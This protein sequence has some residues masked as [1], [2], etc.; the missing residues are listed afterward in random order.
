[1]NEKWDQRLLFLARFIAQWSRDPSTKTG[2]V[3]ADGKRVV[4]VGYNG[5]AA[6]VGDN[7]ERYA[8]R[9]LK[10]KI[11]VH[12]ERNAVLL[13][14]QPIRGCTLYTWPFASCAPCAAMMIQVGIV[15]CVA[16]P[17]PDHLKER[18]G[19]DMKLTEMQY[20][21]AGVQ[22]DYVNLDETAG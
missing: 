2:A 18:W 1:M 13:S 17:L 19:E 15:R 10:Y 11:V 21:E 12:A 22:L 16:P 3:I 14:R 9:E 6:G 5:F 7:P 20:Q 4:S 8:N